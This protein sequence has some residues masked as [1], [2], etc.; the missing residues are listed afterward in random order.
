MSEGKNTDRKYKGGRKPVA[1]P[2]IYRYGVKLNSVEN[3]R[4]EAMFLKS[5]LFEKSRF[6]KNMLFGNK[7]K[8]VKVDKAA[9]DYYMR[10]T[11]IYVQYKAVGVNYNQ[12][13]KALKT[14]FGDKRAMVLLNKLEKETIKLV[15]FSQEILRL[16]QEF[17][18]KYLDIHDK[19]S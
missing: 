12:T 18:E 2:A 13:V 9:M 17:R 3:A 4:F 8:I 16:S 7:M 5:G 19:N 14:N 6:I 11:T 1:D 10:L 15:A